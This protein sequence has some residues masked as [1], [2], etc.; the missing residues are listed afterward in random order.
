MIETHIIAVISV[1]LLVFTFLMDTGN[2]RSAL[3]FQILPFA[4]GTALGVIALRNYGVFS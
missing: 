1:Y 3:I 2:F 4:S